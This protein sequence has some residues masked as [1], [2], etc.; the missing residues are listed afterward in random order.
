MVDFDT[1]ATPG[2]EVDKVRRLQRL[3][4]VSPQRVARDELQQAKKE[5]SAADANTASPTKN[6]D[7]AIARK[8]AEV[9][10]L[11]QQRLSQQANQ[12]GKPGQPPASTNPSNT[13]V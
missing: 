1:N 11:Q 8:K 7:A 4:Q 2:Q 3:A 10:R 13:T 6:V 9:F 12:N 5:V